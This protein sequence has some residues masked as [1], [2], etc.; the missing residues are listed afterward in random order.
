MFVYKTVKTTALTKKHVAHK[1]WTITDETAGTYGVVSYSGHY[2]RGDWDISDTACANIALEALTTKGYYKR[3]IFDSIHHLYYTDVENTTKSGDP[4]Y[5]IHQTRDLNSRIHVISIPS[6]IFGKRLKEHSFTMSSAKATL[7]DDGVGNLRDSKITAM[8]GPSFKNFT[9]SDYILKCDFNDGWKFQTTNPSVGYTYSTRDSR[10]IDISDGPLEPIG[11]NITFNRF[12][13]GEWGTNNQTYLTLHGSQSIESESNS[14]VRIEN[15]LILGANERRWDSDFALSLWVK[16]PLSQS[17]TSSFIGGWSPNNPRFGGT[18][19]RVLQDHAYNVITTSREKQYTVP[20]ELQIYNSS[21]ASNKGKLRFLRGKGGSITTVTSSA[22]N[23]TQWHHVVLQVATGSLQL[24]M[25]G[26]LQESAKADPSAN[27]AI[28]DDISD[29]Y[30]GARRRYGMTSKT[31]VKDSPGFI[32]HVENF[33]Y[34]FKGDINQYRLF[35]KALT[36]DEILSLKTYHRD[37]DIVG[38]VFYNHGIAV[39]TDSSGSYDSLI[40]DYT[41]Q[42]KGT[43]EL[44]IHN[45]QCVVE[46][47]EYNVTLNPSARTNE[48]KNNPKLKGFATASTFAPY[49]AAIGLYNDSNEL[50]AVSKLANP[51]KSPT[52]LDIVFNVQF[53]T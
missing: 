46:D 47:E 19:N 26:T 52:D 49:I 33:V 38:N 32:K 4:E 29:I 35:N 53:D 14:V 20:W 36:T 48:D 27:E 34:P 1:S 17:V 23:D 24:W 18:M 40:D 39:I 6:N 2:S 45:Y 12:T 9:K 11:T 8:T 5:L 44:T 22:I 16:A 25:D 43:K 31:Q 10:L 41:L 28:Y 7:Y 51:V 37:S 3:E 13:S 21:D 15:S 30:I 42:F 50:L